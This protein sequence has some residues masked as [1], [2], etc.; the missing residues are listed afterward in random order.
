MKELKSKCL[1]MYLDW[2]NNFLTVDY[3][4]EYYGINI[5]KA[6]KIINIGRLLNNRR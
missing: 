2:A 1:N 5:E 4:A 6:G 3:F